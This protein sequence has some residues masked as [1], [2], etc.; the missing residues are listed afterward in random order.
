MVSKNFMR[1]DPLLC[2]ITRDGEQG[3]IARVAQLLWRALSDIS[4][5]QLN[6]L[7]LFSDDLRVL[8][9]A[10]KFNFI[11]RVVSAQLRA[12]PQWIMFDHLGLARAQNFV[13][14]PRRA[15][16]GIFLHSVEVW[17]ALS[18]DRKRALQRA[19]VLVA[20]SHYTVKRIRAAHPDLPPI[21]VCHLALLPEREKIARTPAHAA[22]ET[23]WRARLGPHAVLIVG[24]MISTER[25]KGHEQLLNAWRG[26]LNRVPD[27]QLVIVGRGDDAP[28]LQTLARE[29]GVEANVIFAGHVGEAELDV[30]Y[31]CAALFAMPSLGEGFG[32]VYLEAMRHARACLAC[33]DD[34]AAEIVQDGVTG[35]LVPNREPQTLASSL[36]ALLENDARRAA[37]GRAGQAR[38]QNHFSYAQF[39]SRLTNILEPLIGNESSRFQKQHAVTH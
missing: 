2:A 14:P 3:G 32:V 8:T 25:H 29:G 16:Y 20:N 5:Q 26:V 10:Q 35:V 38:W 28:R 6:T 9:R 34:A 27:A 18:A 12:S 30:L 36:S 37:M 19:R 11:R 22:A 7:N 23:E 13:P 4:P 24:R 31:E 33:A 39:A 21:E 17:G 1:T 15:P